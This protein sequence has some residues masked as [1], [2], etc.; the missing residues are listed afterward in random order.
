[1]LVKRIACSIYIPMLQP[2]SE[3]LVGNCNFFLP[4][5]DPLDDL[6]D[7]WLSVPQRVKFKLGTMM[8][9]CLRVLR[10]CS[11]AVPDYLS[12]FCTPVANVAARNQL[13]GPPDVI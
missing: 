4:L 3:I 11:S 9:R 13:Y 8:F 7:F 2:F 5:H 12:D 6:R 10:L 1:M